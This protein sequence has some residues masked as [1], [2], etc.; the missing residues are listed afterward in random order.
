MALE[1]NS[2]PELAR[3]SQTPHGSCSSFV[4]SVSE[5]LFPSSMNR[6]SKS[7]GILPATVTLYA[8][9]KTIR[10]FL[11]HATSLPL[12]L[13]TLATTTFGARSRLVVPAAL[14]QTAPPPSSCCSAAP[15]RPSPVRHLPGPAPLRSVAPPQGAPPYKGK[16]SRSAPGWSTAA[17]CCFAASGHPALVRRPSCPDPL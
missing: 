7:S 10:F 6:Q 1:L 15:P 3:V 8:R 2:V 17:P 4:Y 9:K 5:L 13:P 11:R 16:A 12:G 14:P